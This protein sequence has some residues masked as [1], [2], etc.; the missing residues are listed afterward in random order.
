MAVHVVIHY[1]SAT[2]ILRYIHDTKP[3]GVDVDVLWRELVY[4]GKIG[5]AVV[6]CVPRIC[7]TLTALTI[8]IRDD[9]VLSPLYSQM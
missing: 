9:I 2:S 3:S 7:L 1:V 6:N 8:A 4:M 5:L